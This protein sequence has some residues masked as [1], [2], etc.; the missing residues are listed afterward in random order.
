MIIIIILAVF[1]RRKADATIPLPEN[2]RELLNDYVKF[3]SQLDAAEKE[4]F[5]KRVEDFLAAVKIT[6]V[7]AAAEDLDLLLIASGAV[8]P[9]FRIPDWQ[10]INLHEVLLY[11]G[12]FNTEFDQSGA[13]RNISG[14]VGSGAPAACNGH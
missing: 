1:S 3:Y 6:G 9:V 10:Y 8:I 4:Q 5:E 7:N 2:Y 12:S 14:M 13:D 11:P